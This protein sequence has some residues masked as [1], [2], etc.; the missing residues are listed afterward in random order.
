MA[1]DV[2]MGLVLDSRDPDALAPF[3]AAALDYTVA[4]SVENYVMLVA[5]GDTGPRLLIQRVP[6]PKAGKN[7]MHIDIET[8]DIEALA[9]RLVDLGA[10]RHSPGVACEHNCTWIVMAD[11]EG[12]EFCLCSGSGG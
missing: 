11:P 2:R 4:G 8:T 10:T 6:E 7:R 1:P 9:A 12:N 3:W 5:E